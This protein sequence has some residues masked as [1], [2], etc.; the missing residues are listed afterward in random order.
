M[1]RRQSVVV[2]DEVHRVETLVREAQR[3]SDG[4]QEVADVRA[5][6]RL[7]AGKHAL[8]HGDSCTAFFMRPALLDGLIPVPMTR[9]TRALVLVLLLAPLAACKKDYPQ[10]ERFVDLAVRCDLTAAPE[11]EQQETRM[12]MSGMC[13]EA[14]RND[15]RSV[16]D[17][18]KQ[19]VTEMYAE[20]RERAD[21][22]TS[23][24]TC[25]QYAKCTTN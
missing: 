3:G 22:S 5:A 25:E 24:T 23:A 6:G 10:C 12:V 2:R 15:T 18:A 4:P 11:G 20:L 14:F 16:S 19:L 21:C 1:D 13:E 9:T 8:W 7:D 17:D